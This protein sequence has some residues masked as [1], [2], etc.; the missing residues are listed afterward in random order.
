[1]SYLLTAIDAAEPL[2]SLH[3]RDDQTGWAALIRWKGR[4]VDFW[5][6]PCDPGTTI[7]A[8]ELARRIYTQSRYALT[9]AQL[10]FE[11]PPPQASPP[12]VSVVICT[13]NR[14]ERLTRCLASIQQ[15]VPED[16]PAEVL[17]VDNA[18]PDN[19]TRTAAQT[20]GVHYVM[21]SRPGLNAARNRAFAEAR[22]DW[23]A[24]L[25]DDVIVDAEWWGGLCHAHA[26]NPDADGFTG[27]VMPYALETHAQVLFEQRGGFRRGFTSTRYGPAPHA[28]IYPCN[29]GILGTGAN[30][31]FRRD[32]VRR[33][34]GCDEALDAGAAL[35]GGGDL[36]LFYR[37]IR[38]GGVLVYEPTMLVFHEHRRT[39]QALRD[40]YEHSWGRSLM[41][42]LVKI[43]QTDPATRPKVRRLLWWWTRDT[44]QHLSRATRGRTDRPLSFVIAELRGALRGLCGAYPRAVRRANRLK[45][46]YP[47]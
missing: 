39:L 33:I 47:S 19:R 8:R 34:G 5:I 1:M 15:H 9:E 32:A 16:G 23:V 18:P 40:Q 4:P 31:V 42:Y 27:Q 7:S 17:V 38:G 37:V 20:A 36:D 29:T 11:S 26:A 45:Q 21:E 46:E 2:P 13:H 14:P 44:G 10:H 35:P 28:P 25:D 41:A 6:E 30:M 43:Y 12:A 24:F 22:G 3:L